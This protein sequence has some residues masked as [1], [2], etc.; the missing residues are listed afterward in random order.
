[1][2]ENDQLSTARYDGLSLCFS[3][4]PDEFTDI[5]YRAI[6]DEV[7]AFADAEI[8]GNDILFPKYELTLN[9]TVQKIDELKNCYS[10]DIFFYLSHPLFDEPLCEFASAIGSDVKQAITNASVQFI[11][12]V[13]T[14]VFST[15][16][17]GKGLEIKTDFAGKARTFSS[18]FRHP[19]LISGTKENKDFDM[20]ALFTDELSRYFGSKKAY[21]VSLFAMCSNGK[22]NCDVRINGTAMTDLSYKL[23]L[24]ANNWKNKNVFHYQKQFALFLSDD[25]TVDDSLPSAKEIIGLTKKA[26]DV[27]ATPDDEYVE[28]DIH[29]ELSVLCRGNKDLAAEL[30]VLVPEFY[31]IKMMQIRLGDSVK[32]KLNDSVIELGFKRTQLRK[33]GYVE[34]GVMQYLEENELSPEES[35]RI[36][37]RSSFYDSVGDAIDKGIDTKQIYIKEL[38]F[39]VPD[40]YELL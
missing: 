8:S 4:S 39:N 19:I 22:V 27:F 38:L 17:T 30:E 24:M 31:L 23:Y 14:G 11:K 21:W 37:V 33:L 36:L 13:L 1:M 12:V 28:S 10:A 35:F 9:C 18:S 34:Q 5:A 16:E 6:I 15:F 2:A 25:R 29:S 40:D 7:S 20:L 26:L 32:L 3:D